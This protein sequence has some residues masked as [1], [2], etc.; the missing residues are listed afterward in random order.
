MGFI[1]HSPSDF[2]SCFK[3]VHDMP[4]PD[5]FRLKPL[6]QLHLIILLKG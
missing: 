3:Q 1:L 4:C 6:P 5:C 2:L